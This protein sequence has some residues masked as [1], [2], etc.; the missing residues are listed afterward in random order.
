M[1]SAL[2]SRNPDLQ[3]LLLE[4]YEVEIRSN[5][6][7]VHN[8]PYVNQRRE[9][10]K[11]TLVSNL[12]L[13]GDRTIKP[14]SHVAYFTGDHPCNI[15][16]KEIVQI[17]HT[18]QLTNLAP[19]IVVQHSFSNKPPA[20]YADYHEKMTRY[21]EIISA[22]AKALQPAVTACTYKAVAC[23]SDEGV[24]NY[25]DTASGRAGITAVSA[26]LA[27]RRVAIVGLGGTGS[28][29]LDFL[30]KTPVREIHLYDYDLFLQHNA[31]R[32]PSAASLEELQAQLSK[33]VY[34]QARYAKMHRG[35]HAHP[36]KV[37]AN[38]VAELLGCDFVF[39]CMDSGPAKKLIVETLQANKVPFIDA[40]IGTELLEDKLEL[41]AICRVT[42]STPS[43]NDHVPRRVSFAEAG[44]DDYERNIQIA[45]LNALCAAMAVIK[46]KK[47]CG[48]YQDLEG[49]HDSTYSTNI[50]M[51]TAEDCA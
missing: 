43:K 50:Q 34:H 26:K 37:D 45:E 22:P 21:I 18:S 49:E 16:G 31:F 29:V 40:G 33:V 47:F 5:H 42:T 6:L 13:A 19:D 48:F 27:V 9:V 8:V 46:W 30:A 39:L 35:I 24:F 23:A 38:N 36:V 12:S 25:M 3:R 4:G 7:L 14:E 28:Y 15:D 20:G 44:D 32:A 17:K 41:W 51:L 11:G 2:I 10:T 1:S